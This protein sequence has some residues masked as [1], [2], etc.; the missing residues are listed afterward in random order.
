VDF[1]ASANAAPS[2]NVPTLLYD[3]GTGILSFDAD[4][5]GAAVS[6]DLAGLLQ[7]P[8]LTAAGFLLV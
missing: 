5:T 4:G 2:S 3:T 8:N 6:T 7:A 1:I